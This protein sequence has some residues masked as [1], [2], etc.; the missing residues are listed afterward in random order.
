MLFNTVFSSILHFLLVKDA[1]L[2]WRVLAQKLKDV[3]NALNCEPRAFEACDL[4]VLGS[5]AFCPGATTTLDTYPQPDFL[6]EARLH[7]KPENALKATTAWWQ[8]YPV[9]K[10]R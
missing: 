2:I 8:P 5:Q 4:F 9:N 10:Y 3:W 1:G 6:W 7:C